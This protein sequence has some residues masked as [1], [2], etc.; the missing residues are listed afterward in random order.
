MN[1]TNLIRKIIKFFNLESELENF[2][3]VYEE[4]RNGIIFKGTKL[5]I[6]IF[7]IIIASVGLNMNS[8]AVIIGAMLISPLMGPINGIGYSIA[9]YDF[10][11]FKSSIKNFSFAIIAS[12][13][14]STTYFAITP[15]STAQSE[16]LARTS[17][18]FYDVI[19]ALF[20]GFAGIVAISSRFKGNVI[21]GVAIATA[22]MPPLCT[23]GYGIATGQFKFFFG[24]FYLFTI[25]SIFIAFASVWVSQILKFPIRREID[26]AKKKNINRVITIIITLVLLPSIFFG[27]NL[28][29][30]EKFIQNSNKY[31][32]NIS[33]V[34]G[35][36]LLKHEIIPSDQ[37]IVLVY[38]GSALTDEQ[39][40]NIISKTKDF[41]LENADIFI[42]Q[43]L[44]LDKVSDLTLER[45][46]LKEQLNNLSSAIS[47]RDAKLDSIAKKEKFGQELL[48]ELKT[49]YPQ[50]K[51]GVYSESLYYHDSLSSP[52]KMHILVLYSK[53]VIS[54]KDKIKLLEWAKKRLNSPD[55]RIIFD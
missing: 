13:V 34:E 39:K 10:D 50:V 49:I 31:I 45:F 29:K 48:G 1:S 44:R 28:V 27:Y 16:L 22:L 12:L 5:W 46:K 52:L 11:L 51:G 7:A 21:P 18:T 14:A 26:P 38:G 8:T 9:T 25:N 6:L 43:G 2:D 19:I 32:S 53:T 41:N 17:P 23:S 36:F 20:G 30:E 40:K 55:V 35:N 54:K 15:V 4:I 33:V 37:K 47:Q 3:I 42:E 24:A